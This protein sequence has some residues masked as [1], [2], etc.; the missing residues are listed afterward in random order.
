MAAPLSPGCP[1]VVPAVPSVPSQMDLLPFI[2]KA[3]CECLN[4]SDEHGFEN[5]LRKDSSYLESDCDEQVQPT[6]SRGLPAAMGMF[7]CWKNTWGTK[8]GVPVLS[9]LRIP[10]QRGL[11]WDRMCAAG[12]SEHILVFQ[13]SLIPVSC[14]ELVSNEETSV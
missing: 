4:E 5:C 2:N 12:G 8:L 11:C 3:G 1:L 7:Y 6:P 13:S 10:K 14:A 9:T